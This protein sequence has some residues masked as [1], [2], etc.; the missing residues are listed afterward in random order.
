MALH[1]AAPEALLSKATAVRVLCDHNAGIQITVFPS[2]DKVD[3]LMDT[4]EIRH[5]V[6][7]RQKLCCL[8]QPQCV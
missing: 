3:Y 8:K 1:E 6:K 5:R 2:R 7:L 4:F